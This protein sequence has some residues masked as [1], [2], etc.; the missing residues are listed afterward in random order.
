VLGEH[1]ERRTLKAAAVDGKPRLTMVPGATL[2][3]RGSRT[4]CLAGQPACWPRAHP[5][6]PWR[7][8]GRWSHPDAGS[9]QQDTDP[10]R[11]SHCECLRKY[12][13]M[14]EKWAT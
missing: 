3:Q 2:D 8:P 13:P 1:S 12:A 9:R 7:Q 11:C 5:C 10:S 4:R 6:L 14:D